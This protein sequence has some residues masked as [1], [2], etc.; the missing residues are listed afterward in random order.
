MSSL[1]IYENKTL[2][3]LLLAYSSKFKLPF[4]L[5]YM[6]GA[7]NETIKERIIECL[8]NNE[9]YNL[10]KHRIQN[11]EVNIEFDYKDF[12]VK[13]MNSMDCIN[14][15]YKSLLL[16]QLTPIYERKK[17]KIFNSKEHLEALILTML[18]NHRWG[19]NTIKENLSKIREIFK[20]YDYEYLKSVCPDELYTRLVS[21]NC[22]N[23][24]LSR[25]LKTLKNNIKTLEEIE[26]D[27][28]T[29]DNFVISNEPNTI[30]NILYTG[31]YKLEQ[32]GIS[33]GLEYLRKVGINTCKI[34][35]QIKR[36]LG[37]K[38][39][40]FTS[41]EN[42]TTLQAMNIIKK[43]SEANNLTDIEVESILWQFCINRGAN[44]CSENPK[45][46]KCQLKDK[47]NY[48]KYQ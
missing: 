31:K 32:V 48:N 35:S 14:Y 28:G 13:I 19:D 41:R 26:K 12:F 23:I 6:S 5:L 15:D 37:S 29:L 7:S 45:C 33:F 2:T 30:A 18:N 38:R 22:G 39:L 8:T 40:G 10:G 34:D 25:Q 20:D 47:C 36:L 44:I 21:I 16:E 42:A 3:D 9:I 24:A 17:G 46:N 11:Q 27:Y 4:P 43:I 1:M